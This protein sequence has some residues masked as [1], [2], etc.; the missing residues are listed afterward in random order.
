[1]KGRVVQLSLGPASS[2]K[3][4]AREEMRLLATQLRRQFAAAAAAAEQ[5]EVGAEQAKFR[6]KQSREDPTFARSLAK[7]RN[8]SCS[9]GSMCFLLRSLVLNDE[10]IT[11]ELRHFW[12]LHRGPKIG[13]RVCIGN[14]NRLFVVR[15]VGLLTS[16][17]R[18]FAAEKGCLA[19]DGY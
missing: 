3:L 4:H 16:D 9:G 14:Q 19:I 13:A 11:F 10:N 18:V 8:L 17:R 2:P 12:R 6:R 7:E 5:T 1:M 15:R